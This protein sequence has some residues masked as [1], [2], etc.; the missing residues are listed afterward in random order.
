MMGMN[1]I[2]LYP[3]QLAMLA[4][5]PLLRI[6]LAGDRLQ[7]SQFSGSECMFSSEIA[8]NF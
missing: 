1:G 5:G 2:G 7:L 3:V 4:P 8:Q 6:T